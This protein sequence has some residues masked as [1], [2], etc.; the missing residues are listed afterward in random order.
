MKVSLRVFVLCVIAAQ[1][2]AQ[3]YGYDHGRVRLAEGGVTLQRATD[4]AAEEAQGNAPFLPGDRVWT[5]GGGRAEFQLPDGALLRLD[6]R[7][8]LDYITHDGEG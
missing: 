7:S 5:D 2:S 6:R 4:T 1:A 3:E 8:K